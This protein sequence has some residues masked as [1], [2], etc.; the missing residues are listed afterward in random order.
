[1]E[2]SRILDAVKALKESGLWFMYLVS[3]FSSDTLIDLESCEESLKHIE[4][5]EKV[6]DKLEEKDREFIAKAK[7]VIIRDLNNFKNGKN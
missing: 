2:E 3:L 1:M 6:Q 5:L 4:D 7:S